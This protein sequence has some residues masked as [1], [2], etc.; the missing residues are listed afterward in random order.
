[1]QK[2]YK[3]HLETFG[4]MTTKDR[5]AYNRYYAWLI[6]F[7]EKEKRTSEDYLQEVR[8]HRNINKLSMK[9]FISLSKPTSRYLLWVLSRYPQSK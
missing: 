7:R 5:E 9:Y 6:E 3:W 2:D 4:Y 8:V 1:M